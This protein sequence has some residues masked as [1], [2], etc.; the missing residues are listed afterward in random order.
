MSTRNTFR[1]VLSYAVTVAAVA[2]GAIVSVAGPAHALPPVSSIAVSGLAAGPAAIAVATCPAGTVLVGTGAQVSPST[3]NV[4]ITAIIPDIVAETVTVWGQAKGGWPGMWQ[5]AAVAICDAQIAGVQL[6]KQSSVFD[7]NSK[8]VTAN[9]PAGTTLSGLGFQ[10]TNGSG[11]VFPDD[12]RP[13]PTLNGA[14]FFAFE[15]GNYA[16]PWTLD[17]YSICAVVPVNHVAALVTLAGPNNM[18]SPKSVT[19]VCP[20]NS[21]NLVGLGGELTG[22]LGDVVL[23]QLMPNIALDQATARGNDF[24]MTNW[25][26]TSYAICW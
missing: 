2:A 24:V 16:L 12:L 13:N 14:T 9:C 19:A 26:V 23:D 17:G 10:I 25:S 20:V 5:I 18:A 7:S 8:G 22:G 4:V 21:P 3:G 6:V 11:E 15:N 1:R